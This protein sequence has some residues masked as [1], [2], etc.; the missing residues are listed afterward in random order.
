M[1]L[2]SIFNHSLYCGQLWVR[3]MFITVKLVMNYTISHFTWSFWNT[4]WIPTDQVALAAPSTLPDTWSTR[5]GPFRGVPNHRLYSEIDHI[6]LSSE[7]QCDSHHL[8]PVDWHT[9][10]LHRWSLA[11]F[12]SCYNI[13]ESSIQIW[14]Q[15]V[16]KEMSIEGGGQKINMVNNLRA[17]ATNT[18]YS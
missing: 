18:P 9:L 10:I 13:A 11:H 4:L 2:A 7:A 6:H 1:P 8:P 12:R 16:S 5:K 3:H 17:F 15:S 14:L